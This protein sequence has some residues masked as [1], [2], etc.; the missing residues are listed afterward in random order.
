MS[1]RLALAALAALGGTAIAQQPPPKKPP[2]LE[3]LEAR[4]RQDSLDP[5]AH[6]RLAAGFYRAKRWA[7]EERELRLTIGL[8]P[9][10]APAYLWLGDQPFDRRP[11][12]WKEERNGKVPKEPSRWSKSPIGSGAR[13][14][15]SIP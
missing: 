11:K 5:E 4:A 10:Y 13:P 3:E 1:I 15:S 8:D 7:D 2:P 14:S 12:L 6:F 9:R